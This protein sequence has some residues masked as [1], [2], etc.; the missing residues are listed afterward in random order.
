MMMMKTWILLIGA[1]GCA[2]LSLPRM[3]EVEPGY[4][5][6][7]NWSDGRRC[8]SGRCTNDVNVGARHYRVETDARVLTSKELGG[9]NAVGRA[10]GG[11]FGWMVR[12]A[13][14]GTIDDQVVVGTRTVT[15]DD[16]AW[17]LECDVAWLDARERSKEETTL[18]RVSEGVSCEARPD[19][20]E[21][22]V[23]WSFR[24]GATP[25]VDSMVTLVHAANRARSLVPSLRSSRDGGV[26]YRFVEQFFGPAR[27]RRQHGGWRVE[28]P[29]GTAIGALRLPPG[30][31]C[32]MECAIDLSA[33][34]AEEVIVLRLIAA[35]LG[36]PL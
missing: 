15:T 2:A 14:V 22:T 23:R 28:R 21:A 12:N 31:V 32:F 3:P 26:E 29:D 6:E 16:S 8:T 30:F 11:L 33:P 1:G 19:S 7:T 35:A 18:E 20:N 5:R 34:T 36:V 24:Y 27:K 17:R 10:V 4:L 25:T 13:G 9:G